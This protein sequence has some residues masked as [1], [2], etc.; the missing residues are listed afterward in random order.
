VTSKDRITLRDLAQRV[1]E[2]AAQPEQAEKRQLW[3]AHNSLRAPRPLLFCSPEGSWI[4]LLPEDSLTCE[5]PQA[6]EIERALRMRIYCQDH[7]ADDQVCDRS[8]RVR[9]AAAQPSW[10]LDPTFRYSETARG[11]YVW[12]PPIKTRADLDRL[13]TPTAVVDMEATQRRLSFHHDLF[14]DILDVQLH[15]NW[16]WS[17]GL[18]DEWARLRGITQMLL[19]MSD[20]PDLMHAGMARLLEGKLA[21]LES[22]ENQGLLGLNNA[23]DYVGSGGFGFTDELPRDGYDGTAR[24]TDLWGFCEAQTFSEVGPARHEEFGLRYQLPILERFGLNCYGCC[25]PL[26]LKLDPLLR[27]VPRLRRVSISP[28]ANKRLCAEQL[29]N[30]AIYS[31][32]PNP[33]H[34]AAVDFDPDLVRRDLRETITLCREHGC[35]LEIILKDTHTCNHQPSR[36][37][38][39]TW[40]A[41]EEVEL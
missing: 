4:E 9:Y 15:G 13:Q 23:N 18:V 32:K 27:Q 30:R 29:G 11:S 34:L 36:F 20:D 21:W 40:I 5:D 39:W 2:L 16:W 25:E 10:G 28:W 41:R 8:Y 3:Y 14:G 31:W 26:H 35:S 37:D 24:L 38:Q 12:D 19:D 33:A 7:F 22:L 6:R 17:L 1:A